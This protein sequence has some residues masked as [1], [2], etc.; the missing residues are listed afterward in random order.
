MYVLLFK[1]YACTLYSNRIGGFCANTN[2]SD[3]L[4]LRVL[5]VFTTEEVKISMKLI[6]KPN[7]IRTVLDQS[8]WIYIV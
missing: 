3:S 8:F 7:Q 1:Y 6:V 5:Y 2:F 4:G